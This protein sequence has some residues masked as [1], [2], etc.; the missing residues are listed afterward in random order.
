MSNTK[1]KNAKTVKIT[2]IKSS[3]GRLPLHRATLLGLGLRRQ[4]QT[5]ELEDTP[6]VWGMINQVSYLLSVEPSA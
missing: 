5:V 1:N 3:S 2:L 6:C 4:R